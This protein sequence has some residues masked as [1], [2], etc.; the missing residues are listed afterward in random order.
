MLVQKRK[1]STFSIEERH[2]VVQDYLSSG[3]K[4]VEIWYKYT[5]Q[6]EEH[7]QILRWM[8]QL[9]YT[10]GPKKVTFVS[11]MKKEK[12]DKQ[13]LS[14]ENSQLK[15]K[16]RELQKALEHSELKAT[17]YSTMIDVAEEELKISIRKK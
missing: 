12:Q 4:K 10:E 3:K 7:G 16:I 5:G 8:R 15:R 13:D 2:K 1:G 6:S 14:I 17:A 9:G 11:T